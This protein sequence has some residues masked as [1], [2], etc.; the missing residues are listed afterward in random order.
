MAAGNDRPAQHR[1]DGAELAPQTPTPEQ[2]P[3]A[4]IQNEVIPPVDV[5]ESQLATQGL[6]REVRKQQSKL[7]KREKAN[8][9]YQKLGEVAVKIAAT[10][11]KSHDELKDLSPQTF[12]QRRTASRRVKKAEKIAKKI[13]RKP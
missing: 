10:E 7:E 9:F 13:M 4:D 3:P 5:R 6:S 11:P 12:M 1:A 2:L 8:E